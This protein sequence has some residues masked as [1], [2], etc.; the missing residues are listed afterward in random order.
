M[1]GL[2]NPHR[3]YHRII[4]VVPSQ[5]E[6]LYDLGLDTEVVGI[7]K[8]CVHPDEWFR[9]KSRVGGTKNLNFEKI[10]ELQPD[11]ILANKEEN[12]KE[13]IEELQKAYP[14]YISD[15]HTVEDAFEMMRE[16]GRLTNKEQRAESIITEIIS[17]RKEHKIEKKSI[18]TLYLI[19]R[20]PYMA[21]GS[22]TF[23][24]SMMLEA[25]FANCVEGAR[26]PTLSA[27]EIKGLEPELIL[28]SSEPYPFKE[29]HIQE[30]ID[31]LPTSKILLTDGELFSWYGSRM[32]G[33][34]AYFRALNEE[35]F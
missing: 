34:F 7:T 21:A 28:L 35:L 14:V 3:S 6:L 2:P 16:I 15:I 33:S 20:E 12:T 17:Q 27:E 23:I 19:W 18:R 22:D 24:H 31:I 1:N 32:S 4:S 25:G 26:Y 29:K 10:H 8:F 9:K 30:L 11:L 5:T 13:E